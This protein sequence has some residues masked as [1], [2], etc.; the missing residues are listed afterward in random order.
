M[1]LKVQGA[2][3]EVADQGHQ[4]EIEVVSWSWGM[5]A[6]TTMTGG[7][8][9]SRAAI[10]V[11]E[12]QVVKRVDKSSPTL[13][14][15]LRSRKLVPSVLLVVR[16]AGATPFEYFKIQLTDVRITGLR[17]ESQGNELLE[18]L[19]LAFAK[20]LVTYT[21]QGATGGS[22]GGASQFETDASQ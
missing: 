17:A 19:R 5:D 21:P 9:M 22:G 6:P 3:G 10:S 7:Q 15:F 2:T 1:F 11:S 12:L 4:G 14:T 16:K 20:V 18:H 13:M 8:T